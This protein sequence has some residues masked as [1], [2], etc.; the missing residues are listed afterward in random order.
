MLAVINIQ[1]AD[2]KTHFEVLDDPEAGN[3]HA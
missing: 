1:P 3:R 2:Y